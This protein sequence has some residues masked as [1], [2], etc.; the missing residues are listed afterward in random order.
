MILR[1][2]YYYTFFRIDEA[3]RKEEEQKNI[4]YLYLGEILSDSWGEGEP[5]DKLLWDEDANSGDFWKYEDIYPELLEFVNQSIKEGFTLHIGETV[6]DVKIKPNDYII[7]DC[8]DYIFKLD[9]FIDIS[10]CDKQIIMK[11]NY[12]QYFRHQPNRELATP[13]LISKRKGRPYFG[14]KTWKIGDTFM[15]CFIEHKT[16]SDLI[17]LEMVTL[18]H[19]HLPELESEYD[20]VRMSLHAPI[21]RKK[22]IKDAQ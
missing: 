9:S 22:E 16:D 21:F 6:D 20:Y 11:Y 2:G 12:G 18:S 10:E 8:N 14:D 4:K 3:R 17:D 13:E 15:Y 7:T 5:K 1:P 19:K